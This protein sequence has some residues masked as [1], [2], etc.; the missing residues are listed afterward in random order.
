MELSTVAQHLRA[1]YRLLGVTSSDDALTEQGEAT[2]EV[3]YTYLTRGCRTAQRW[4]LDK[5]YSGWRK[6]SSAITWSGTEA[7]D[8]GR[9]TALPDDFLRLYGD[10]RRRSALVSADGTQWGTE[11]DPTQDERRGDGYYLKNQQL[12]ILRSASPPTTV[13]IDYHYTHPAWSSSLVDADIDFPMDVRPLIVAEAASAAM[14]E[15]WLPGGPEMEAKIERA[16]YR[17]QREALSV[18]RQSKAPREFKR[19]HRMGDRW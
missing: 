7:S 12:W 18:A 8:G 2:D 9:Y 4:M 17:A 13:Y 3:G 14:D 19:P 5:G 1:L 10:R 15:S 6:R 11:V 16:L